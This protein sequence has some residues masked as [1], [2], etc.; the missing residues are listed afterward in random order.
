MKVPK[1]AVFFGAGHD[2]EVG[3]VADS[4]EIAADDED[5]D[6]VLVDAL[7]FGDGGVDGVESSMA[8]EKE[9]ARVA[10]R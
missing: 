8:L 4:L 9:S 1:S 6:F 10:G 5:V 3:D 7:G 2:L